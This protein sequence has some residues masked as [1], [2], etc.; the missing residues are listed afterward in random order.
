MRNGPELSPSL[1]GALSQP[2]PEVGVVEDEAVAI[3]RHTIVVSFDMRS[4]NI[5]C[6]D[7]YG[8]SISRIDA[9]TGD[10]DLDSDVFATFGLSGA[11]RQLIP[12]RLVHPVVN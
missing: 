8:P 12:V 11:P 10:I 3:D 5:A 7:D 4:A 2:S 1:N 9:P 6:T